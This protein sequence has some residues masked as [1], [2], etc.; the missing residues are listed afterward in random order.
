MPTAETQ[1]HEQELSKWAGLEG[2]K[3]TT[4][5]VMTW[6]AASYSISARTP[7]ASIFFILARIPAKHLSDLLDF[8]G[9]RHVFFGGFMVFNYSKMANLGFRMDCNTVLSIFGTFQKTTK[10]RSKIDLF[11]SF[12]M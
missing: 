11:T 4:T 6:P 5:S 2:T 3:E 10:N 8:L 7:A 12:F 9:F 1:A